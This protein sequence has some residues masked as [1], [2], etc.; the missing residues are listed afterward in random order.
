[1][2]SLI[3]LHKIVEDSHPA[4]TK[5]IQVAYLVI[6]GILPALRKV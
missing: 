5:G 2:L 3:F 1:M 6:I 4:F